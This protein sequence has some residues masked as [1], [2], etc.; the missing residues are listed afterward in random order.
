MATF[1]GAVALAEQSGEAFDVLQQNVTSKGGTTAEAIRVFGEKNIA[2]SIAE[3][4][5][6]CVARS[7]E[8]GKMLEQQS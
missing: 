5:A 4:V 8:L 2:G 6:A 1:K 3:G 7:K